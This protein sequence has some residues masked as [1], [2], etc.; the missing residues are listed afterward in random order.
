MLEQISPLWPIFKQ[1]QKAKKPL[2]LV[3]LVKTTGSSYK[4]PGA[5]MLVEADGT[6]H[7][8]ISG[9]CLEADVAEHT[10]G[11]FNDQQAITLT[12]DMSDDSIFGLGAGCDGSLVLVLQYLSGDYLPFSVLNPTVNQAEDVLLCINQS[13]Q[14]NI[15]IGGF[16]IEKQGK[17]NESNPGIYSKL[18]KTGHILQYAPPPK[19]AICGAGID[20]YPLVAMTELLQ[21]HTEV[22][23][24]RPGKLSVDAY[25]N[26]KTNAVPMKELQHQLSGL[27]FDAVIIMTHNLDHDAVYLTS[28]AQNE[29]HW[30]GLLGPM[31]RR[32]KV[33][34]LAG[35]ELSSLN[36]KLHAPVGLDIGGHMPE[37]IAVSIVAQLQQYFLKS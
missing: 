27:S 17:I 18:S 21:W 15:P 1:N 23:D 37:N 25:N 9:G 33:L 35:L 22:F 16:F 32:D 10:K 7:G 4:K 30:I 20:T 24:H 29:V 12:Y 19:I 5:M 2:V 31:S 3:T 28:F 36:N 26:I 34:K 14:N 11:V 8:L 13:E 6:T